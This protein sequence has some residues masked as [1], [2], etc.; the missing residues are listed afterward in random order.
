MVAMLGNSA[1]VQTAAKL[2]YSL[3]DEKAASTEDRLELKTTA[4][5]LVDSSRLI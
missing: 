3:A 4:W 5:M 1:V 2:D